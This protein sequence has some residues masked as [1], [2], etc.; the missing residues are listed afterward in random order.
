[1]S[2]PANPL[3]ATATGSQP[4]YLNSNPS[5]VPAAP[6]VPSSPNPPNISA[7]APGGPS[8][9]TLGGKTPSAPAKPTGWGGK[10]LSAVFGALGKVAQALPQAEASVPANGPYGRG[11]RQAGDVALQQRQQN[12]ENQERQKQ[13][14]MQQD[15]QKFERSMA[16][17]NFALEQSRTTAE[18]T[19]YKNMD[20]LEQAKADMENIRDY[21]RYIQSGAKPFSLGGVVAPE[22]DNTPEGRGQMHDY[23]V[24]NSKAI[25]GNF[26]VQAA[27]S[28]DGKLV[29]LQLPQDKPQIFDFPD[30]TK[31]P[32]LPNDPN[33]NNIKDH[34]TLSWNNK[35]TQEAEQ[36]SRDQL[37]EH[38]REFNAELAAGH[39]TPGA[40]FTS[41]RN[42]QGVYL[43]VLQG[44]VKDDN[45]KVAKL[46]SD[47]S[48][49]TKTIAS[50]DN[51]MMG[52][53][54][55]YAYNSKADAQ[56]QLKRMQSDLQDAMGV[57]AQD[58][59]VLDEGL[60]NFGHNGTPN[61]PK[62]GEVRNGFKFLGGNPGDPNSWQQLPLPQIQVQ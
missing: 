24:R 3:L 27:M 40:K 50:G 49:L 53:I 37:N 30:G 34:W 1:M 11:I 59:S 26:G 19:H 42:Q 61:P 39:F 46:N 12:I 23:L 44:R 15:Q 10:F 29:L 48:S 9:P 38:I 4:G 47:I 51:T 60:A 6:S 52:M 55:D 18:L 25:V 17:K 45:D 58:K 7:P 57:A 2:T 8:D 5:P 54:G 21:N 13:I 33:Y 22:F 20:S 36:L 32:V 28:P 43:R 16:D 56:T 35:H 14:Q 31:V 62:V 41:D